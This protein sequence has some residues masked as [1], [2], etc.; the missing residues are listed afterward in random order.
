MSAAYEA[1]VPA[2][3]A[4]GFWPFDESALDEVEVTFNWTPGTEPSGMYGPPEN[5]DPG[6]GDYFE[7][8]T[9]VGLSEGAEEAVV[10]WLFEN[11]E[12]PEPDYP[13]P[14]DWNE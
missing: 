3:V 14:V 1:V 7:I 11:W 5:Y 13:E 2:T 6:E 8:L 4:T 12:R 10:N 9:P